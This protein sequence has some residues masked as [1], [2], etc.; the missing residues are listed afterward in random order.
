M[1]Q[2]LTRK[3]IEATG[4]DPARAGEVL[5]AVVRVLG[6]DAVQPGAGEPGAGQ[7]SAGQAR[8]RPAGAGQPSAAQQ[9]GTEPAEAEAQPPSA[10]AVRTSSTAV[11]AT[12][13]GTGHAEARQ[14]SAGVTQPNDDQANGDRLPPPGTDK[15]G[16][17]AAASAAA[18]ASVASTAAEEHW[19]GSPEHAWAQLTGSLLTHADPFA[20]HKLLYER[21][22]AGRDPA[23][24]P[25]PAWFPTQE[26]IRTTNLHALMLERGMSSYHELFDWSVAHRTAFWRLMVERL[27]IRFATPYSAVG[28]LADL[29][30]PRWFA[31]ARLNI[32]ES[33]FNA[34]ADAVAIVHQAEGGT[35]QSI[36]YGELRTLAN[37]VANG[38]RAAGFQ[39]GDAIGACLPLT[40]EAVAI[41]LGTVAA[42]CSVVSIADS[43]APEEIRVR[44]QITAA[45]A[46]FTQTHLLR[47]GKLLPLYDKVVAASA[48][49]AIVLPAPGGHSASGA[50]DRT[51]SAGAGGAGAGAP[52]AGAPGAGAPGAGAPGAG[53]PGAGG[54]GAGGAGGAGAGGAGAV[55][56]AASGGAADRASAAGTGSDGEV[57][58]GVQT[59]GGGGPTIAGAAGGARLGGSSAP[60]LR[61]GDLTWEQFLSSD[62]TFTAAVCDPDA[63]TNIL[64]SSGT[65]GEPKAIPW[66]HS[67]PVKCAVD[68]HLHQDIRP[69]DVAAWPTSIGW[70]M[71]PWLIYA[72]LVNRATIALF[73]GAPTGREFGEFIQNARV[74]MLGVVPSLVRTWKR[75]GCMA[76][77]DWST[78][79]CFS[80]TG[81]ASNVEDYLFLMTLAGYRPIIEYC[82]GTEIGGGYVTGT[83]L[84]PAAPSTFTTPTLGL[85]FLILDDDGNPTDNGEVFLRPPSIGLSNTLL[86]Q[87][88]NAVYF[89]ET[90]VIS[91]YGND[92][93]ATRGGGAGRAAAP[94]DAAADRD[95]GGSR[96]APIGVGGGDDADPAANRDA[97]G[98]GALSGAP[99]AG[100]GG[101]VAV[102]LRRH[103]DQLE[104]LP[105]GYYRI[106]GRV[107]DTM[108]LGGIKVSSIE[109][110]RLLNTVPGVAE[111]AAVAI[112]PA[113]GGPS[114]LVI[115]AALFAGNEVGAE[116]LR[117]S[118]Q[119]VIRQR[120]NPLFKIHDVVLVNALPRTA[121]NKTVR[122]VLRSTY[123]QGEK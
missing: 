44:L 112:P 65:T 123:Q 23:L 109:I 97:G 70:M 58:T 41:Y 69:G 113:G 83:M 103:G 60:G 102:P 80:S 43:F 39:P 40:A 32:A 85:D 57:D 73:D 72:A 25:A 29:R 42:G 36:T 87:D 99:S 122:R 96:A 59:G 51:G 110:E 104:R 78:I 31:G 35:L 12:R 55:G 94:A 50:A 16:A 17:S 117:A 107:D 6:P 56:R 106:H 62:T 101:A 49:Q 46:I 121:S 54:A 86:N 38:L 84:Q 88:H 10:D 98:G 90:P 81:E 4:V 37:R 66:T 71:G 63:A 14:P 1:A 20:L 105:D 115:Y 61:T 79:R 48:P 27:G 77:L 28:D 30:A 89:A 116:G 7:P 91:A 33:C 24:G 119:S 22:Y 5:A 95:A 21:V 26:Q 64:F 2:R 11:T 118:F 93:V 9:A 92:A 8:G 108:N 76:G 67:T 19:P 15:A 53:A 114:L 3:A 34:A 100:G 74:T 111:T 82:G 68:G 75:T 47:G 45:K 13:A 120:L 18:A 52:G